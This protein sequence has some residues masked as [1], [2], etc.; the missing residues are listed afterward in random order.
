MFH[1]KTRTDY[2]LMIMVELAKNKQAIMSL[3]GLAKNLNISSIYLIQISRVLARAGL[4]KSREGSRGGY[5]LARSASRI[6][7][8]EILEILD[9]PI[10]P[11]C[12]SR[13]KKICPGLANCS[14]PLIWEHILGDIKTS[15]HKKTLASLVKLIS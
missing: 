11:R 4:I 7:V 15:L 12:L 10:S 1:L 14:L 6:S 5:F 9:G 13:H 3:S 8:L 2:G